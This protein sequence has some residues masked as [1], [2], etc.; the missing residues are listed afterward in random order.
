MK[1]GFR[2]RFLEVISWLIFFPLLVLERLMPYCKYAH[3]CPYYRPECH[4]CQ[5]YTAEGYFCGVARRFRNEKWD[6]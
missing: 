2:Y 3:R 5:S 1:K 6:G 4:T